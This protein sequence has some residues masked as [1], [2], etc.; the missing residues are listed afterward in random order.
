MTNPLKTS[1]LPG[2]VTMS[3]LVLLRPRVHAYIGESPQLESA[4][5]PAPYDG[6]VAD[7][8][9]IHPSPHMLPCRIWSF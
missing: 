1:S 8:L 3:N 4:E 9:D 2:Y 6:G 5:G 7:P